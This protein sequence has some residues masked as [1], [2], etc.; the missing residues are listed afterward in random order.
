MVKKVFKKI[1]LKA[2]LVDWDEPDG[3]IATDRITVD[4]QG[5]GYMYREVPDK[6]T[7]FGEV[8]SGWRFFAGD[9]DDDYANNPDNL[10][11]Y[12]LNTICNYDSAIVPLLTSPYNSAYFKNED[13]VFEAEPFEVREE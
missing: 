4:G 11:L 5:V 1:D 8:D 7:E 9:E 3:C 10:G 13:G 2:I 12:K 6:D